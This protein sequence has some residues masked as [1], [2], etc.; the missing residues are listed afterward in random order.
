MGRCVRHHSFRI[1]FHVSCEPWKHPDDMFLQEESDHA[2]K[3][4]KKD[5]SESETDE[6]GSLG[7]AETRKVAPGGHRRYRD[8]RCCGKCW[9]AQVQ[10]RRNANA[11]RL[12]HGGGRY[13]AC[14]KGWARRCSVNASMKP[15]GRTS[16]AGQKWSARDQ[17]GVIRRPCRRRLCRGRQLAR[18]R[19]GGIGP[20]VGC[21]GRGRS[22]RTGERRL[23]RRTARWK[24][25]GLLRLLLWEKITEL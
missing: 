16:A 23:A 21:L 13:V 8:A 17:A 25:G 18:S 9:V 1:R 12:R 20:P 24:R 11:R 5:R 19:E 22:E 2:E 6:V 15:S 10:G 7:S 14:E 4:Q 3:A